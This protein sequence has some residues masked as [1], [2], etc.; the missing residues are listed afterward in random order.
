MINFP[1]LEFRTIVADPPWTPKMSIANG[2]AIK[3]S[4]QNFYQTMSLEEI[5][6][7]KP[8]IAKQA[9]LYIWCISQHVDWAYKVAKA[10]NGEPIIL[11]T[12]KKKRI[13]CRSFSMQ[14]R[15]CFIGQSW[16]KIQKSIW[17]WQTQTSN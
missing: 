15:T 5:C 17:K 6:E 14:Y 2:K 10:W 7:L 8:P 13:R 3:A 11:L 4:P 12:W 9:H 16:T 1:D